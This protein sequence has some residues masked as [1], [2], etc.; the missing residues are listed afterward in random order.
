MISIKW[1]LAAVTIV[2]LSV[3]LFP[4]TIK[5][6]S[7]DGEGI[8][9]DKSW[10]HRHVPVNK[11]YTYTSYYITMTDGTQ[12]AA[13]V[14]LPGNHV[15]GN[16]YPTMLHF[17]RYNRSW[18]VRWPFSIVLGDYL[19]TRS[20]LYTERFVNSGYAWVSVDVRGT[21]ASYG[22]RKIDCD[23]PEIEDYKDILQWVVNQNWCNGNIG[24]TGI[25]YDGIASLILASVSDTVES[26]SDTESPSKTPVKAI[27]PLYAPI[28]IYR[29][30]LFPGGLH[31]SGFSDNYGK[32]TYYLE[33]GMVGEYEGLTFF[34]KFFLAYVLDSANT[35]IDPFFP[36]AE[37]GPLRQREE[38]R[39]MH[40]ENWD[41][42][43]AISAHLE[44]DQTCFDDGIQLGE[45]I[46]QYEDLIP[47]KYIS[48]VNEL[49]IPVYIY[50]AYY[51]SGS[52]NSA[53]LLYHSF[54]EN[55]RKL[56]LG[57]W[58]HGGR[59]NSSPYSSSDTVCYDMYSDLVS[60]FDCY[61]KN[62]GDCSITKEP[63][64]NYFVVG[65]E[66]WNSADLYP[67]PSNWTEFYFDKD[68][69]LSTT[70]PQY[71]KEQDIYQ[72]NQNAFSS[73]ASR[74][75]LISHFLMNPVDYPERTEQGK[76]LHCYKTDALKSN[77]T[78]A[79]TPIV[80][81]DI[82]VN[83]K[84][85]S[86]IVYLEDLNEEDTAY[87][88]TEGSL[89]AAFRKEQA[90]EPSDLFQRGIYGDE[91]ASVQETVKKTFHSYLRQ[92]L[93][94]LEE[95]KTENYVIDLHPTAW[96]FQKG[97]KIRVCIS[98]ADIH[99]ISPIKNPPTEWKVSRG[100][101]TQS[102]LILPTLKDQQQ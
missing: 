90:V 92:D 100:K 53:V 11:K 86:F 27:A 73:S 69:S 56:T 24:S 38:A 61:L 81:F 72:V 82:S 74:W 77:I 33:R 55:L 1:G 68:Y 18:K 2:T 97:H 7:C 28:D 50:S 45:D 16:R 5:P 101:E 12:I 88:V 34:S 98:G 62:N 4:Y 95:G 30:L 93:E 64:V 75:N 85:A 22:V 15:E 65:S 21:G 83:S 99:N 60:Y 43:E 51:D 9:S 52:V 46:Y 42:V 58:T 36:G 32:F 19:N 79:G 87:Y 39:Q 94:Y 37:E 91:P 44:D 6:P 96:R 31:C 20:P 41:M 10:H 59:M 84:D 13:D 71:S 8:Y 29:D 14:Y 47:T 57:P 76:H 63:P 26:S 23:A 66:Q 78:I 49:N 3:F 80:S 25:S 17:T 35:V 40:F 67:V 89:R 54:K 48:K 102:K 70:S